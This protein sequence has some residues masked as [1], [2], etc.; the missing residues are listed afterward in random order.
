MKTCTCRVIDSDVIKARGNSQ[1]YFAAAKNFN[2]GKFPVARLHSGNNNNEL[3]I[4]CK[5]TS[6]QFTETRPTR[7]SQHDKAMENTLS[8][9]G[10][11]YEN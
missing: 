9:L 7:D 11:L 5:R 4:M 1:L 3:M 8:S 6:M 10:N 2:N